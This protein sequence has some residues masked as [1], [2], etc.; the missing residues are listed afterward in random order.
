MIYS[1]INNYKM[2]FYKIYKLNDI[3]LN[4]INF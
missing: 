2:I 4:D 3:K 1:I